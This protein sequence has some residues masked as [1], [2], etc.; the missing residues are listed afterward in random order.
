MGRERTWGT[1]ERVESLWAR[2]SDRRRPGP[3][4]SERVPP[5]QHPVSYPLLSV[6]PQDEKLCPLP[7]GRSDTG[8]HEEDVTPRTVARL[9]GGRPSPS[10]PTSRPTRLE[11]MSGLSVT[12]PGECLCL[13]DLGGSVRGIGVVGLGRLI[14]TSGSLEN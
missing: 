3:Q 10:R 14:H 4:T 13:E 2:L 9:A 12:C 7:F 1:G 5:N 8:T 6:G 11:T